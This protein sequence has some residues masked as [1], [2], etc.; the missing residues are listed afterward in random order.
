[1]I[2]STLFPILTAIIG[3][4]FGSIFS[5]YLPR[6]ILGPK[7]RIEKIETHRNQFRLVVKNHGRQAA[8]NAVGRITIKNIEDGDIVGSIENIKEARKVDS[9]ETWRKN[10][11]SYLSVEDWSLGIEAEHLY[12]STHPCPV[13]IS[14]NPGVPERLDL[15]FSEGEWVDIPSENIY[16]KRARLQLREN[17]SYKC[18]VVICS[19]NL[20]SSKPFKFEILLDSEK[21]IATINTNGGE[22]R[23][24]FLY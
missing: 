6:Y 10:K 18:E 5:T 4:F 21:K 15:A 20:P 8:I 24:I 12:W 16:R 1:M 9:P 17:K 14:L 7:I 11:D 22:K 13:R 23:L 3:G 19:E 2:I